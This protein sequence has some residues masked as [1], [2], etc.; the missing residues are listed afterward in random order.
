MSEERPIDLAA[1][2]KAN[3][4]AARVATLQRWLPSRAALAWTALAGAV[5][6]GYF[7]LGKGETFK[8]ADLSAMQAGGISECGLL[9]H[10]CLVDGDTGWQNGIKWRM[11]GIDAPEMDD[12]AECPNEKA[13]ARGSLERLMALM[14]NGYSVKSSGRYDK[15][16]RLLVDV[17][18]ADGRDA[19]RAL[20]Q[21]GF[22]QPWPNRGNVWCGR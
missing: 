1:R 8:Q 11:Q 4:R 12:K 16:N 2:R 10:T 14:A 7:V 19:G 17:V 22:A 15:Y 5:V 6:A 20:M 18:L 13:K 21:E 9:R 3:K